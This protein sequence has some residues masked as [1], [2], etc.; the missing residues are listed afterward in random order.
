[1]KIRRRRLQN[2]QYTI[3][4]PVGLSALCICVF[5]V[6]SVSL[7]IFCVCAVGLSGFFSCWHFVSFVCFLCLCDFC[8]CLFCMIYVCLAYACL[9]VSM[10]SVLFD[11]VCLFVIF[12]ASVFLI[13]QLYLLFLYNLHALCVSVYFNCLR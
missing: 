5:Y 3:K 7:S 13:C 12:H 8:A 2:T 10:L 4:R 11:S 1:M 9:C 6:P